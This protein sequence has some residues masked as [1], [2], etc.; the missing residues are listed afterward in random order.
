MAHVVACLLGESVEMSCF[1][2]ENKICGHNCLIC[3][4]LTALKVVCCCDECSIDC[5]VVCIFHCKSNRYTTIFKA[6]PE[7]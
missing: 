2:E 1:D 3:D 7:K 5:D 6:S 4:L